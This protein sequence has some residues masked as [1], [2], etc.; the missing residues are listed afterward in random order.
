MEGDTT[1]YYI[2]RKINKDGIDSVLLLEVF[3]LEII[4][5][6]WI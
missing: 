4:G 1:N 3:Q 6:Y 5:V 2:F